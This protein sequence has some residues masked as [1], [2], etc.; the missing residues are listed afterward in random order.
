MSD[1][2]FS[3]IRP[4]SVPLSH[5]KSSAIPIAATPSR[6][7]RY[8]WLFGGLALLAVGLTVFLVIPDLVEPPPVESVPVS[9]GAG[10]QSAPT[11]A[12][13]E[14]L[15]PFE[16][17]MREQT[18][19]S[20]QEELA[21]FVELQLAL[22]KQMQVGSWGQDEYDAAK[23]LA[24]AGDEH[25]VSEKFAQSMESYRAA[26]EALALLIEKGERLLAEYL[27]RA[28]Q[29]LD[30]R[31]QGLALVNFSQALLIDP[32]N[33]K[34]KEGS[35][36]AQLLPEVITLMREGK[37][38]ELAANW[39]AALSTF[40]EVQKLDPKTNGLATALTNARRGVKELQLAEHLSEGFSALNESRYTVAKQAFERAL[41]LEAG[42]PIA[43][44]GLEQVSDR[45]DLAE[46]GR[47]KQEAVSAEEAAQWQLAVEKY[48]AVLQRDANL[49]FAKEGR[50]RASA[51]R[52]TQVL[53]GNIIAS[54]D[55]LSSPKLFDQARDILAAA[56]LLQPRGEMLDQQITAVALLV[57][58][59]S[60]PVDVT[61]R[62]D[63]QTQ[64][65]LSSVGRLGTF[66]EKR[67][68]LRPGAYTVIG[69]RDGCRDV[70][71]NI[72]V[73]PQMQPIDIRCN[74]KL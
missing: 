17:L 16:T 35:Q 59:Y 18:R 21:T 50:Q 28:E 72:V 20:A 66:E 68:S 63:N 55:K 67:L 62:S 56:E 41:K 2:G 69:S 49:Q 33:A 22:E 1:E 40:N 29:A 27:A 8:L 46:L 14:Q 36:R 51:Q 39:R 7:P 45:V 32:D 58:T 12:N 65:T 24:A 10:E 4:K 38:H 71:T 57:K 43:I 73:K 54:P 3:P 15:P 60:T 53:L 61:F 47:L 48:T 34:G 13:H 52:R 6:D 64:I 70:R 37:N 11:V 26:R 30:E 9:A 31:N 5:A 25:F 44:G 23:T 19:K 74:E 42:N